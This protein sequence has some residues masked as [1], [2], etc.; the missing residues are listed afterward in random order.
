MNE[1]DRLW[2][3]KEEMMQ[4]TCYTIGMISAQLIGRQEKEDEAHKNEL[5]SKLSIIK[6][7]LES[8]F[9]PTFGDETKS[10]IEGFFKITQDQQLR[11]Y[12]LKKPE[13][14][15]VTEEDRLL[16]EVLEKEKKEK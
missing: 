10:L 14:V 9:I 2:D 12:A 15:E 6:G 11:E 13:D 16:S 8:R 7:G 4:R 5:L 1:Q 3:E